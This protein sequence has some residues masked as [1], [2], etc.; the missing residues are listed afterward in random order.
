[1]HTADFITPPVDD[2]FL[3]GQIGAANS[4]SDIYAMGGR[5]LTCLNLVGFPASELVP[6]ILHGIVEGALSKIT[7]AGAVL[8]GGHTTD[9]DEPKFGLSVTG[10]VHPEKYWRNAG[11]QPG[12]VLILTKPI[13]SGVLFNANLKGWVSDWALD[14]CIQTITT[15]NKTAAEIFMGVEI[16]AATDITGYG[17]AGHAF[18]MAQASAVTL[19]ISTTDIP[20]MDEAL[21]MYEKGM[22]TGVN[23]ANRAMVEQAVQFDQA[24]STSM[25]ELCVDPQTSGGLL[26]SVSASLGDALLNALHDGGI[27]GAR[28]IGN[29]RPLKQPKQLVFM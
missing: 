16:H 5:P 7:E 1:M 4:I 19:E 27:D 10:I 15:L 25:Q 13:G 29:V 6:E 18:E 9:D 21:A 14:R 28:V 23:T 22:T 2:P 11:A 20:T 24:L 3:F 26:V 12:D 8:A 17:L